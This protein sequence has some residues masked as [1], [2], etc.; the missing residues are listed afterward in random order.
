MKRNSLLVLLFIFTLFACGQKSE[1]DSTS[2]ILKVGVSK[3]IINPALGSFIAGDQQNR[4]FTG[5]LD[6]LYAKAFVAFDGSSSVALV[7]L[8]CI[9]LMYNDLLKVRTALSKMDFPIPFTPESLVISSTHTHSGPDVVGLWGKDFSESGVDPAYLDH[10]IETVSA[11]VL[12]ASENLIA[13]KGRYIQ[14]THGEDWVQ[15]ISEEEI[16]RSLTSLIFDDSEGNNIATLTNFACHP[17]YLDAVVSEVSADYI[18]GFYK[19]M[20]DNLGGEHLFF[21]GA[22]GGW[23]QPSDKDG[24]HQTAIKRGAGLAEAVLK[25][26]STEGKPLQ[27]NEVRFRKNYVDFE[28]ENE[29]W[30]QLAQAS[31]VDRDISHYV[32]SEVA[33]FGIGE[34]SFATHPGETAPYYSIETKKLMPDGPKFILGLGQDA[35]G[36]I[37]K[38]EYYKDYT[39]SHSQYLTSMSLG[40]NSG[41]TLMEE[42]KRLSEY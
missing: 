29:V 24:K 33:W 1:S 2:R 40:Q 31:I 22:I 4:R 6:S 26:L 19:K 3:A 7:T 36:Y 16:D 14:T 23:I 32:R 34:A 39:I 15:N 25:A 35:L 11:E 8:D 30:R 38:P 37:L 20:E 27:S 10:L 5:V 42:L 18:A 41:P 9:G 21:Q 12:K 13:V 17:T 28:V